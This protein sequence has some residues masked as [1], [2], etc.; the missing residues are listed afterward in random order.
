M[1]KLFKKIYLKLLDQLRLNFVGIV[2]GWS[3]V[4]LVSDDSNAYKMPAISRHSFNI[5]IDG[6]MFSSEPASPIRTKLWLNDP[7]ESNPITLAS[8]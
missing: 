7:R 5:M 2:I 4:R 8:F 3:P 6:K 1:G